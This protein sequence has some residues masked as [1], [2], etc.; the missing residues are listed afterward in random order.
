M[1]IHNSIIA[2]VLMALVVVF[3]SCKKD[4]TPTPT[5]EEKEY[6]LTYKI[7]NEYTFT[8]PFS[9]ETKTY[10]LSPCFKFDFTYVDANG[11]TV[12]MKN[13]SAPWEKQ[14]TV[15]KPFTAKLEGKLVYEESEL[16]DTIFY[17]TPYKISF[18][19]NGTILVDDDEAVKKTTK[20]KFM[21]YVAGTDRLNLSGELKLQ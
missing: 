19:G 4:P 9:G 1:K 17:G 10:T 12:E 15:K 11:S 21:E 3:G 13:V 20:E 8:N 6:T 16:P 14:L 18:T 2:V 7:F 5:P